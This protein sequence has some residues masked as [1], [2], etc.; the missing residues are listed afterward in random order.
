[1]K[2]IDVSAHNENINW[3]RVHDAG[4][5]FAIV[6]TGAGLSIQDDFKNT[7]YAAKEA[8]LLVGAYHYSY[9]LTPKRAVEEALFCRQIIDDAGMLLELPVWFDMEDADGYKE[10][11]GFVFS[12]RNVT[13]IC[14]AF[15]DTIGL[16]A[17]VYASY[18]WF[19]RLIDW[20]ALGCAVWNAQW[21]KNDYLQGMMW[22]FTD[23]LII[24]GKSYDGNII[25]DRLHKAG[26]DPWGLKL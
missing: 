6:R 9:A 21:S 10:R 3:R 23:R 20:Q 18:D 13:A 2:G 24:D 4:I 12:R 19:E 7:V 15:L 14:K 16:K 11:H 5:D 26:C 22:Q 8:G 25:Y 1:M 17:G